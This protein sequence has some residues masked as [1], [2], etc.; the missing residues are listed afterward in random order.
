MRNDTKHWLYIVPGNKKIYVAV[1]MALSAVSGVT[2]VLFA[3]LLR[4]VVDNAVARNAGG[5]WH[6]IGLLVILVLAILSLNALIRWLRELCNAAFENEFK[7]RLTHVILQ[8]DY[9]SVSAVHTGIW[10]NRLTNDT[11]VVAS[12]YVEI[13]AGLAGMSVRLVSALAMIFAL[14]RWFAYILVPGGIALVVLSYLFR[15]VLKNL[16][17][18]MQEEDG[19]LRV[20]LQ[21]RIGSLMMIHSFAAENRTAEEAEEKMQTHLTARMKRNHFHNFCNVGFDMAMQGMY[22]LGIGYCARG[23]LEGT[24]TYGTLVAIMQLIE[25]VQAPFA[26][27][28]GYL[29][30]YYAMIASA[31]RLMEIE[32]FEDEYADASKT[33]EEVRYFYQSILSSFGL[34]NASF[35]YYVATDSVDMISKDNMP[36][37]INH[38]SFEI[39]K[40]EYIAFT[41]HSGC[42]KSTV[43]K[44]LMGLY[45]VDEGK[46]FFKNTDG[47]EFELSPEWR[48]LFAYVPQG[49]LLM[50]GTVRDV[51]SFAMPMADISDERIHYALKVAC[52]DDF[53]NE[54]E[55]GLDTVLGERGTGL[56]EGQMQRL[57]IARAVYSD[58]PVLLLD[59]ATSALDE[60]TEQKLL[61]NLQEL[62]DKTV[63]IVTH[64]TAALSICNRVLRFTD[65]GVEDSSNRETGC[66]KTGMPECH[67]RRDLSCRLRGQ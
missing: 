41:G 54:L 5:F 4:D 58:S 26:N 64:R 53:V 28:S 45:N 2:G 51:V 18:K 16:H 57:A 33:S 39:Q 19:R 48:R 67:A 17:K 29:P 21:E 8:K 30:R 60:Q 56:S 11:I 13:L 27:I 32:Q 38:L 43:L 36:A 42:G 25:Q 62:T 15:K 40:G 59:E 9:A 6:A 20:F 1:L 24:V 65:H 34:R 7:K 35:T 55:H 47:N 52:A 31:E 66:G 14:D 63:I 3:L 44:L 22:L 61:K 12:G 46:R 23:I 37:A 49:N 10:L 50:S